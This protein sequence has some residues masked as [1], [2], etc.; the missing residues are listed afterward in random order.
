MAQAHETC[1]ILWIQVIWLMDKTR[2]ILILSVLSLILVGV[3][4]AMIN[5]EEFKSSSL[6][7]AIFAEFLPDECIVTGAS[8]GVR[9]GVEFSRNDRG[10]IT[11]KSSIQL[12]AENV[13]AG[14][15]VSFSLAAKNVSEIPIA[16][17]G[18]ELQ[19][20][21]DQSMAEIMRFDCKVLVYDK[22]GLYY[23]VLGSFE[24]AALEELPDLLTN[25]MKYRKIDE[26]EKFVIKLDQKI[27]AH[28]GGYNGDSTLNYRLIPVF[29]Q[30]FPEKV[31]TLIA[32]DL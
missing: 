11:D 26:S 16:V 9:A 21:G 13:A 27:A 20:R 8:E 22:D 24:S 30:Y 14:S 17:D 7:F 1:A 10:I 29:V 15:T 32:G 4:Y 28:T 23:E 3:S 12:K 19:V 5:S 6:S 31:D 18:C 25:I 2:N